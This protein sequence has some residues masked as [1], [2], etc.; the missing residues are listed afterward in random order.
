M[1]SLGPMLNGVRMMSRLLPLKKN[2]RASLVAA[3]VAT[4]VWAAEIYRQ[5]RERVGLLG[6]EKNLKQENI[7]AQSGK[8]K[9]TR[10]IMTH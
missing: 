6:N 8:A 1:L 7:D 4:G 3:A 2:E 9:I 5:M 10:W